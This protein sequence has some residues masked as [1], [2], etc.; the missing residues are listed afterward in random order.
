MY[1]WSHKQTLERGAVI[2]L[3][4]CKWSKIVIALI[5]K[6]MK[7]GKVFDKRMSESFHIYV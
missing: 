6:S 2:D 3:E 4:I 7:T 5:S 1:F